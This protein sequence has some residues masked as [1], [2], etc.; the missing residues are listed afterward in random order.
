MGSVLHILPTN[1]ARVWWGITPLAPCTNIKI[2][3]SAKHG[4]AS[5]IRNYYIPTLNFYKLSCLD[6][7]A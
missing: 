5:N 1:W 7:D 3:W 2:Y 6:Y 4:G